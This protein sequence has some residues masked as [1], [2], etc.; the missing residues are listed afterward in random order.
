MDHSWITL[1]EIIPN[2]FY[3]LGICSENQRDFDFTLFQFIAVSNLQIIPN[4]NESKA[5]CISDE[6]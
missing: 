3:N 1:L 5:K 4:Q 6:F 2:G